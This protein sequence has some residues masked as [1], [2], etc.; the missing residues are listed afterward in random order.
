[1]VVLSLTTRSCACF[2]WCV[3]TRIRGD[4]VSSAIFWFP[5]SFC[6]PAILSPFAANINPVANNVVTMA[7][8]ILRYSFLLH[9]A[10]IGIPGW[11]S[12]IPGQI[13]IPV[14]IRHSVKPTSPSRRQDTT[15][16]M[17][18]LN[19]HCVLLTEL[20]SARH[21]NRNESVSRL[22][23]GI[24]PGCRYSSRCLGLFFQPYFKSLDMSFEAA[25]NV[26]APRRAS[27][28]GRAHV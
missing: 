13:L 7:L 18:W 1:M 9:G 28:I 23:H 19:L 17:Y 8:V 20:Q 2:L 3:P 12:F 4:C 22:G 16:L 27:E 24:W 6:S 14:T 26:S 15:R 5:D 10:A 25:D 21:R 11:K